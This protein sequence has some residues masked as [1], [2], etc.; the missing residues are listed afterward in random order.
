MKK[1]IF[2]GG[3]GHAR[4]V[5]DIVR[6]TG[7][8]IWGFVDVKETDF[9]LDYLGDDDALTSRF[10][11]G[12]VVLV[13]GVGSVKRPVSRRRVFET[14]KA[15]GYVFLTVV[16]PRAV[17]AA[18]AALGEG[19]QVMANA[20]INPGACLAE[21]VIVNT[22][23]S[24][25]HDCRI[26]AHTHI[27]PGVTLSGNVRVGAGCHIGTG[28]VVIQ[29]VTLGENVLVAAGETVRADAGDGEMVFTRP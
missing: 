22:S 21:D 28:A 3:G 26:G 8:D 6:L 23:A 14:F 12:E 10:P 1:I 13:N 20:V 18:S 7:G 2:I 9:P 27:A 15:Q 11:A 25:D 29:G 16:H 17:I 24:I 4:V 5:L 19:V